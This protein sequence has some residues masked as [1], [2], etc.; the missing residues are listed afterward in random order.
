MDHAKHISL[1]KHRH[2]ICLDPN[3]N[4]PFTSF[5]YQTRVCAEKLLDSLGASRTATAKKCKVCKEKKKHG[6]FRQWGNP[7]YTLWLS[8][9]TMELPFLMGKSTISM[10]IFNSYVCLPEG[11]I[12]ICS[13][14]MDL[15][16]FR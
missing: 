4:S 15:P 12:K 9:I 13:F 1:K 6:G 5:T 7:I 16:N 11:I 8:N 2:H 10:A 14:L 3:R